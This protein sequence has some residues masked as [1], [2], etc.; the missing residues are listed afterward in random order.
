M[1][2]YPSSLRRGSAK[3]LYVGANPTS[4]L[5]L[6]KNC[7][8]GGMVYAQHLK[9]CEVFPHVGSTPTLGILIKPL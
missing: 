6:I 1:A 7:P 2:E 4:A 5:N 9:C 3:P 8:D